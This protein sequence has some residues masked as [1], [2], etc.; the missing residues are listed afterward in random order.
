MGAAYAQQFAPSGGVSVGGI[1]A[2]I[3]PPALI[4]GLVTGFIAS[5][6]NKALGTGTS[7]F[8]GVLGSVSGTI[9]MFL[10]IRAGGFDR[11]VAGLMFLGPV[12]GSLIFLFATY[13]VKN[14]SL[15]NS[16]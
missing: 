7:L 8:A 4:I 3:I 12:L 11:E 5:R 10:L 16:R 1:I 13:L 15:A 14:R 6:I 2:A 9:G